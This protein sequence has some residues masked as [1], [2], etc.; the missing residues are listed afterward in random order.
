[1]NYEIDTVIDETA[2]DVEWLEQAGLAIKYGILYAKAKRE[3]ANAEEAIKVL[4]SELVKKANLN[5]DKYLGEEVKPTGPNV[6]AFY[7]NHKKHKEAKA[8]LIRLQFE[9][10]VAEIAKN[11]IGF[12]RKAALENLVK[13][14]GQQYFA[15]PKMP[16][17][18]PHE[19]KTRTER[20]AQRQK[21]NAGIS[22]KMKRKT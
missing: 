15:G 5:P 21:V 8:N 16:R 22:N 10:D 13:L 2:L 7:R 17:D 11:E 14:H 19:V 6:E 20:K 1:M 4:R 18:L 9:L 3:V 12:T